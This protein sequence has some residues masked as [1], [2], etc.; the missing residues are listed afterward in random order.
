MSGDCNKII[1]SVLFLINL[2]LF[3]LG[4][5]M[6]GFAIWCLVDNTGK[7]IFADRQT[8]STEK[9]IMYIFFTVGGITMI[10]GFVGCFG[11]MKESICLLALYFISLLL[12]LIAMVFS[13]SCIL[14][15]KDSDT[16]DIFMGVCIGGIIIEVAGIILSVCLCQN[17][18][19]SESRYD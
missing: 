14:L 16:G 12:L 18:K 15:L 13:A 2:L 9:I 8:V 4:A 10:M 3:I 6:L 1:K 7:I 11:I 17:I 5:V 19:H